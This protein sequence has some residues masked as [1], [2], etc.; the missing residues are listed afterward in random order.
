MKACKITHA[1]TED[2]AR[3]RVGIQ[4]SKQASMRVH[5]DDE[6]CVQQVALGP[7]PQIAR[8]L[9]ALGRVIHGH[10]QLLHPRGLQA[11]G[12]RG[13]TISTQPNQQKHLWLTR[14]TAVAVKCKNNVRDQDSVLSCSCATSRP[15]LPSALSHTL[16][17]SHTLSHRITSHPDRPHEPLRPSAVRI[18]AASPWA[19]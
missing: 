13:R 9:E 2:H 6:L 7:G 10:R 12:R 15:R 1:S 4:A 16:T 17:H 19:H 11:E 8:E 3:K 5:Q 14:T 18:R